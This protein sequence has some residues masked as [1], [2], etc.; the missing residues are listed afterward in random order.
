MKAESSIGSAGYAEEEAMIAI[1]AEIAHVLIGFTR[2]LELAV[3]GL[4]RLR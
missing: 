2:A 1:E 4:I 3:A